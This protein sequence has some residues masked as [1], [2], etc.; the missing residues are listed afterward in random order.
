MKN[1]PFI[2]WSSEHR[3]ARRLRKKGVFPSFVT[4]FGAFEFVGV[5]EKKRRESKI[6]AMRR[7]P[8]IQPDRE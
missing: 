5:S 8:E 1:R 7:T 6:P 2:D 3:D 4:A